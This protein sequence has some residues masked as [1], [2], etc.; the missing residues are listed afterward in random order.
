MMTTHT[1]INSTRK[2]LAAS[3]VILISL[4]SACNIDLGSPASEIEQQTPQKISGAV[5]KGAVIGA[6]VRIFNLDAF[7][8]ISGAMVAETATDLNGKWQTEVIPSST[9]RLIEAS[10]GYFIDE[11]DPQTDINLKRKVTLAAGQVIYGLLPAQSKSAPVSMLTHALYIKVKNNVAKVGTFEH[12]FSNIKTNA[13]TAL[14]FNPFVVVPTNPIQPDATA[15]AEALKYTLLIGGLAQTGNNIATRV[16][17]AKIDYEV[18]SRLIDDLQD[19]KVNGKKNS[20]ILTVTNGQLNVIIPSDV[21]VTQQTRIFGNNNYYAYQ[22]VPLPTFDLSPVCQFTPLVHS[23]TDEVVLS[24]DG[25]KATKY[26]ETPDTGSAGDVIIKGTYDKT[27]VPEALTVSLL[28]NFNGTDY[29][30]QLHLYIKSTTPG[31]YQLGTSAD[32]KF[33]SSGATYS[34]SP[35]NTAGTIIVDNYGIAG[36]DVI[37]RYQFTL[38]RDGYDCTLKANIKTFA[39][40]FTLKRDADITTKP[41]GTQALPVLINQIPYTSTG[42]G[43]LYSAVSASSSY[44]RVQ[45][46]ARTQTVI[47]LDNLSDDIDLYV[48]NDS[49]FSALVCSSTGPHVSTA[50][51]TAL[52][53]SETYLYV[54]VDYAGLGT[55]SN[56]DISVDYLDSASIDVNTGGST[57]FVETQ[58]NPALAN[59]GD[60][61]VRGFYNH[62]TTPQRTELWLHHSHDGITYQGE[63][64]LAFNA[65]VTG[66]YN[67]LT[68]TATATYIDSGITYIDDNINANG[69]I[70]V[71]QYQNMLGGK[72]VA[73]YILHLCKQGAPDCVALGNFVDLTGTFT[74]KQDADRYFVSEGSVVSPM[75]LGAIPYD[76]LIA[77]Q[78]HETTFS[79]ASYYQI[80]VGANADYSI[81]LKNISSDVTLEVYADS[82]YTILL[83]SSSTGIS[84]ENCAYSRGG[85][86]GNLYIKVVYSGAG[87]GSTFDMSVERDYLTHD[88]DNSGIPTT[89]TET[90]NHPSLATVSMDVVVD[91]YFDH[92]LEPTMRTTVRMR[93][94]YSVGEFFTDLQIKFAGTTTGVFTVSS[95]SVWASK[96]FA[97]QEYNSQHASASGSVNITRYTGSAAGSDGIIEG[98]YNLTLCLV[99]SDCLSLNKKNFS[100]EFKITRN[101]DR[102]YISNGSGATP[103]VL[104]FGTFYDSSSDPTSDWMAAAGGA[105][106]YSFSGTPN[107]DYRIT[108]YN[109][110]TDA[111]L[112]IYL[113]SGFLFPVCTADEFT[114]NFDEVCAVRTGLDSMIYIKVEHPGGFEGT[115]YDL[116]IERDIFDIDVNYLGPISYIETQSDPLSI[117]FGD[118]HAS[119][120][121]NH[122]TEPT[123]RTDV[124]LRRYYNGA[125]FDEDLRL[126]FVTPTPGNYSLLGGMA[127]ASYNQFGT[128]YDSNHASASGNINITRYTGNDLGGNGLIEGTY[129]VTLC[130][131][132]SDCSAGFMVNLSGSFSVTHDADKLYETVGSTP[133]SQINLFGPVYD[134]TLDGMLTP[135]LASGEASH[136]VFSDLANADYRV[137]VKNINTDVRLSLYSDASYTSL[138]CTSNEPGFFDEWCAIRSNGSNSIYIK[139]DYPGG[140]DEGATFDLEIARDIFDI[141]VN[142]LGPISYIE[143]Q[144][145]PLSITFGDIHASAFFNH[146]TE[147]TM[148]TDVLLRRYYNGAGFDED[149]RLS[150]VT[151]TP[152]NYSLLGGMA[153]A[154]YNQFGTIYDSNHASASGNINITRYT[155][156]DLGGNGLIEGTY[157]VTLCIP[158]SDCSAGFMVN[159]SGSFS[160][161]HDA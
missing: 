146:T 144:S 16:N 53:N 59:I 15:S 83:C 29:A 73:S 36:G 2:F 86:S 41:D 44:Y 109:I 3:V 142:Y 62:V 72:L 101:A 85:T 100:G 108:A 114:N 115:T 87:E 54:R 122:T 47:T 57:T 8:N 88:I 79:G 118:I 58:S 13:T 18:Y 19:C 104:P 28:R 7:G 151:P 94:D 9:T 153:S 40:H 140:V 154:S 98:Y 70:N 61:T 4:T 96:L 159:L 110:N 24:I 93:T 75:N 31:E 33:V 106:Y 84:E 141:D 133:G 26:L 161:T 150:F 74:V 123:M 97:S 68:N 30:T 95:G 156:N 66:S 77:Q 160:V 81:G 149:L 117:T 71:S 21:S 105:S 152:G 80:A 103:V 127:S 155:G 12:E 17:R 89:Y 143:T 45:T 128:I 124:L 116:K 125:G 46:F 137:R 60:V 50:S 126:S 49:G 131:P 102:F 134:S 37:G 1:A 25:Q 42:T 158:G 91:A 38:C 82:G 107:S 138:I 99:G 35:G 39:G 130:I 10:G 67:L 90:Y 69:S 48:F 112:T 23:G 157:N 148:R 120:F 92:T 52:T 6:T 22:T 129:N 76:S 5:I 14:G 147:P 145:D 27:L 11:T 139:V 55:G 78:T 111:R 132:G 51:C 65:S 43:T 135:M 20:T 119:A 34:H 56:Y 63:L 32:A 136:F 64:M 113:D 121:F